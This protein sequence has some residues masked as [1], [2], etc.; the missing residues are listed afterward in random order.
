MDTI[1]YFLKKKGIQ[2][3]LVEPIGLKKYMLIRVS[4]NVEPEEWFGMSLRMPS[5]PDKPDGQGSGQEMEESRLN[6]HNFLETLLR[7]SRGGKKRYLLR[8]EQKMEKAREKA[9]ILEREK[10]LAE[11]E[12]L[13]QQTQEELSKLVR[14]VMELAGEDS[15]CYCVYADNVRKVL[16]GSGVQGQ[17]QTV[18][19]EQT[20]I[21][22]EDSQ[23]EKSLPVLWRHY[24][25]YREFAGYCHSFWVEQLMPQAVWP[26][27]VILG[28]APDVFP[29]LEKYACKMK[30]LRWILLEADYTE[31]LL[32]DVEDFYTEYGLAIELQYLEGPSA[33]KKFC[34]LCTR[35]VNILDF[36]GEARLPVSEL[37]EGS[38]WLDMLSV[39][40]KQRRIMGRSNGIQYISLKEKWKYAQRR[41]SS[42]VLP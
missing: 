7:I 8:K 22:R 9:E 34:L 14:N 41:C 12:E 24:F 5:R 11:R 29:M 19:Q 36:T 6:K 38:V 20:E 10:R 33:W 23:R 27:F 28:T 17:E 25:D 15:D 2:A 40:E 26:H 39:E 21:F 18:S 30:S 31:E 4:L 16:I 1:L 32:A 3:P 37:P 42:P 13:L 35:P